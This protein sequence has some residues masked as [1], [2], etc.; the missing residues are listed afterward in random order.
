MTTNLPDPQPL[1]QRD[2]GATFAANKP[3]ATTQ[4]PATPDGWLSP[5]DR[6]NAWAAFGSN[7][8]E[9]Q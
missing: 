9:Q 7:T 3:A 6:P 4:A 8:Q 5:Y 2:P 1:P